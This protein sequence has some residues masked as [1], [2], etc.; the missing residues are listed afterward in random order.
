[1][2]DSL[3]Q[4]EVA[5]QGRE[6]LVLARKYRPAK[7]A[8]MIGQEA[9]VTT[10][11]NAIT[12]NR[13]AHAFVL[14]GIRGVG[15]T[16][17]ARII[18]KALNCLN[19][20]VDC[21]PCGTC[22]NCVA[23]TNDRHQDVLEIDAASHTSVDQMRSLIENVRYT[24]LTARYKI[25]I[26][27]EVH[28]LS[29]SA[30]NAL[31]K[32]LEE[33]PEHVKFIFATTEAR[34]I[35]ITI[36]SRCQRFDLRRIG[37]DSLLHYYA[38]LVANENMKATSEALRLIAAAAHGS[39]RDGLSMLDQALSMTSGNLKEED[40]RQMLG[41]ANNDAVYKLFEEVSQGNI[42]KVLSTAKE[43]Y[44]NGADPVLIFQDMLE[45][46]HRVT[47][48]KHCSK[49][50]PEIGDIE[51]NRVKALA[52][53]LDTPFLARSWQMMLKGLEEVKTATLPYQALEM[54]LVRLAYVANLPPLEQL[55]K[56][57]DLPRQ[58][59]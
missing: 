54:A 47:K 39:V 58:G 20:A 7:F 33:P 53:R 41:I 24:P 23:I 17:T 15:K 21:E 13:I 31:L 56:Q 22:D 38:K 29:K 1:M 18:A 10:L 52:D 16:T 50:D 43:I 35:P 40:V 42:E 8:D 25:Y 46:I 5:S 9:M 45:I 51:L 28:M 27:D 12:S 3:F 49:P 36:L 4:D 14:T 30:F 6:Y 59:S 11:Q 26:I 32:T 57:G 48:Y 37:I 34:K 55:I 2:H 19:R 44:D